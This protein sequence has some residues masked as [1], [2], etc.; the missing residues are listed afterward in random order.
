MQMYSNDS[1]PPPAWRPLLLFVFVRAL[2]VDSRVTARNVWPTTT[3]ATLIT[4]IYEK[5]RRYVFNDK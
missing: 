2:H 1:S 3:R 4:R 5:I